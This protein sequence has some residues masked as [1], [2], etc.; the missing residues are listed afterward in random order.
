MKQS[1]YLFSLMSLFL[2]VGRLSAGTVTWTN[3]AGGS[4]HAP[5]NWEPN[6]VPE[7]GDTAVFDRTN[8]P[9]T[10]TWS[11][12]IGCMAVNVNAGTLTWELNGNT[13]SHSNWPPTKI[14]TTTSAVNLTITNGTVSAMGGY[15]NP[16]ASVSGSGTV[17]RLMKTSLHLSY[18]GVGSYVTVFANAA[19]A[20]GN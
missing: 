6:R 11:S 4:Y 20:S 15:K 1:L 17:L 16:L 9:Y 13:Y 12:S 19:P 18:P 10:V 3:D 14:G 7:M 8:R 2:A 5:E